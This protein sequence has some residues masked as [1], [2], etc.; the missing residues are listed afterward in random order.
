[1]GLKKYG[2]EPEYALAYVDFLSHLNGS[3]NSV[4][5]TPWNLKALFLCLWFGSG[6]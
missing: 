6:Y 1:M 5:I 3:R 4:I 2:D